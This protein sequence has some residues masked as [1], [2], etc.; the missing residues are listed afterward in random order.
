MISMGGEKS[1]MTGGGSKD[2]TDPKFIS[3]PLQK[4]QN[5]GHSSTI[6]TPFS[7]YLPN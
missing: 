6:L 4:L 5:K 3:V 1:K 7:N 2:I